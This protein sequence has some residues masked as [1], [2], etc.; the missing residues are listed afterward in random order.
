[1]NWL[2]KPFR[3]N[4]ILKIKKEQNSKSSCRMWTKNHKQEDQFLFKDHFLTLFENLSEKIQVAKLL[5]FRSISCFVLTK[6]ITQ[7][8]T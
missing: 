7:S 6:I 3:K 5:D 2:G 4:P 1:M 8:L